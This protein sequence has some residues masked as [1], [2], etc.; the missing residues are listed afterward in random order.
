MCVWVWLRVLN[1]RYLKCLCLLLHIHYLCL[2]SLTW[3]DPVS[4]RFLG[5]LASSWVRSTG[6]TRRRLEEA[7]IYS[8][9]SFLLGSLKTDRSPR[10]LSGGPL[11]TVH[12]VSLVPSSLI[13]SGPGW[14]VLRMLAWVLSAILVVPVLLLLL[15][16][17]PL[18]E[19][20]CKLLVLNLYF[21][22]ILR[23][24]SPWTKENRMKGGRRK[25]G[26]KKPELGAL[27]HLCEFAKAE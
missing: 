16:Y 26:R 8:A 9:C 21:L 1:S 2:G 17:Y 6:S 13:P 20:L 23:Y 4:N 19:I 27:W 7:G 11:H 22:C 15:F 14:W 10:L 3:A 25:E 5:P 18:Y 12:P 24:F